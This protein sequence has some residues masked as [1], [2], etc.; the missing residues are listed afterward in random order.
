MTRK[1][2]FGL[3][4]CLLL[5]LV[6]AIGLYTSGASSALGL[7]RKVVD[8]IPPTL[9]QAITSDALSSD[10]ATL[11]ILLFSKTAGFRHAEAIPACRRSV[12][13]IAKRRGW[14]VFATENA[15]VFN[16]EQLAHFNVIFGNNSSGDNWTKKQKQAFIEYIEGG[17]GFVGVHGVGGTRQRFWGWYNDVL[18]RAL[19][20]GHPMF[21]QFQQ[22]TVQVE[23]SSHPAMQHLPRQWRRKDEWYSFEQSP[24]KLGVRVLARLDE[25]SYDAVRF[26]RDLRMGDHP[27]IWSHCV[28]E[29]GRVFYSALGHLREAYEDPLHEAMLEGAIEWA[30]GFKGECSAPGSARSAQGEAKGKAEEPAE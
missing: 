9:P 12:K 15:A 5:A 1:H 11:K 27:I 20:I 8:R 14:E 24:R 13:R 2:V 19:F 25:S 10:A 3:S 16:S 30:A 29:R 17:G 28:A 6:A 23:D 7:N 22:A 21:P 4:G 26:S 18:L